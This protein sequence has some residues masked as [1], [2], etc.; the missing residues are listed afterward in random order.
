MGRETHEISLRN[1][2]EPAQKQTVV[3]SLD[4]PQNLCD[5]ST[6]DSHILA[7]FLI[8]SNGWLLCWVCNSDR[9]KIL[10]NRAVVCMSFIWM[11]YFPTYCLCMWVC[12][13]FFSTTFSNS[14]LFSFSNVELNRLYKHQLEVNVPVNFI[15][16]CPYFRWDLSL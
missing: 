9:A 1:K 4:S 15:I 16:F 5:I 7:A 6:D 10:T 2:T 8:I 14:Y 12:V 3:A 13:W 11:N